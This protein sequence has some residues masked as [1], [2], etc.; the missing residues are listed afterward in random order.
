M[1][2]VGPL[3]AVYSDLVFQ[4]SLSPLLGPTSWQPE[5][6]K[7]GGREGRGR[8]ITLNF[9]N[10]PLLQGERKKV[11][12]SKPPAVQYLEQNIEKWHAIKI[13]LGYQTYKWQQSLSA[14]IVK[15]KKSV[16]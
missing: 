12:F 10:I 2:R 1:N 15:D 7:E 9:A 8:G 3:N 11:V 5:A 16:S 4:S 6:S 13:K 14:T